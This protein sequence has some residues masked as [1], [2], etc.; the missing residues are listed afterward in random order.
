MRVTVALVAEEAAGVRALQLLADRGHDVAAVFTS[1]GSPGSASPVAPRARA[2]GVAVR[3]AREVRD[4]GTA[5]WIREQRVELLLNVYSLHIVDA[6]VLSA[7]TLG[8]YNLHPG[9]LPERA[10]LHTPSWALY[11]G[12]TRYGVTLHR[13]TSSVDAGTIAFADRFDID[14][15]ETGL[16]LMTRCVRHGMRLVEELLD[17]I[18]RGEEVPATPQDL[19]RRRW[20]CPGP[21]EDGRLDWDRPARR[22]ADFVRAC[23]YRPFAS[24]WGFPRCRAGDGNVA[25]LSARAL[26]EPTAAAPGTVA[27]VGGT[28][29]L[30]AARDAWVRVEKVELEGRTFAAAEVIPQG[31]RLQ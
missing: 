11:E 29:I 31:I 27:H 22:I 6:G 14:S 26:E 13:M 10:G 18:E 9:P 16:S 5:D 21:P 25:I 2:L 23:D 4:S 24:P 17:F 19:K 7:P 1:A 12:A 3:D 8:A 30:V 20:F 28:E 15:A